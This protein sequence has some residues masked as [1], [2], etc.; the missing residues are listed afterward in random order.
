MLLD[1]DIVTLG[2]APDGQDYGSPGRCLRSNSLAARS[3]DH[4]DREIIRFGHT[5]PEDVPVLD[6]R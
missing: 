5:R 4:H 3:P 6:A 2:H 1:T